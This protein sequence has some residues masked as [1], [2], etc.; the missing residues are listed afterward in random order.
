MG[1]KLYTTKVNVISQNVKSQKP[2]HIHFLKHVLI[3]NKV[4]TD[5]KNSRSQLIKMAINCSE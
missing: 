4:K 2:L 3:I 1:N 5:S